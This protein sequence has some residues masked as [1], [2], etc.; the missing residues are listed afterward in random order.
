MVRKG[1]GEELS[2][3]GFT[4]SAV[5]M[6]APQLKSLLMYPESWGPTEW[7][8]IPFLPDNDILVKRM[9]KQWGDLRSYRWEGF[10]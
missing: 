5:E 6:T 3:S 8:P 10:T 2:R 4:V 9:E 7:G 1:V